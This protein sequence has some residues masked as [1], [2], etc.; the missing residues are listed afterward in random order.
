[1]VVCMFAHTLLARISELPCV[2]FEFVNRQGTGSVNSGVAVRL[3]KAIASRSSLNS[4]LLP[5]M[6]DPSFALGGTFDR[7]TEAYRMLLA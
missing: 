5:F 1:M 7:A 2:R 3:G 4:P 6:I